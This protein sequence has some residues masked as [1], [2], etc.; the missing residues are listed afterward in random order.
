MYVSV[1]DGIVFIEGRHPSAKLLRPVVARV[2]GFFAQ[3]RSLD[4]VK[5]GLAAQVK[6]SGGNCL[7]DF[8]YG[9]KSSFFSWDHV[10]WTG[11]GVAAFVTTE[12]IRELLQPPHR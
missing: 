9:Q 11:G 10:K 3:L 2:D 6:R 7:V 5:L 8:T 4:D 12:V 1:F